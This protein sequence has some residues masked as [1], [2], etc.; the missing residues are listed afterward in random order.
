M[1][2]LR[3][4][5]RQL[6]LRNMPISGVNATPRPTAVYA[7]DPALPR[8]PQNSLPSCL[9]GFERTRLSL[10]SSFQLSSRTP[11]RA[12]AGGRARSGERGGCS[13]AP[14]R[15][16]AAGTGCLARFC[17][18]SIARRL[19]SLRP[20]PLPSTPS[21]MTPAASR[22]RWR[23]ERKRFSKRRQRKRRML[24]PSR[25]RAGCL[26]FAPART[27]SIPAR[28]GAC[29]DSPARVRGA[30]PAE[31]RAACPAPRSCASSDPDRRFLPLGSPA[32]S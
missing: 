6:C 16:Q 31:C 25:S 24:H 10:A 32:T 9:L 4:C 26:R 22:A 11:H 3:W 1:C 17:A 8:R 21:A 12:L 5:G 18:R 7:S 30:S 28:T 27:S 20:S 19:P 29:R 15:R 14:I 2:G 23:N 13:A